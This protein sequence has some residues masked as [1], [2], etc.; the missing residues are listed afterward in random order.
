LDLADTQAREE[1]HFNHLT[2]FN[3]YMKFQGLLKFV[4]PGG[5]RK[6]IIYW[7][8]KASKNKCIDTSLLFDSDEES[9]QSDGSDSDSGTER[10]HTL[11]IEDEFIL[12]LM[13]LRLGLTN[14]DLLIRFR[15][16]AATVFNIFITW[17]NFLY[18]R[19]GAL[20][21]WLQ[22]GLYWTTCPKNS[23]RKIPITS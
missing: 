6:N 7:N 12:V 11:A 18:I 9:A 16:S 4:L 20:K 10:N 3:S 15:V 5:E 2:G 14:L 22:G 17:L 19:L 21:V 8:T 13:K 23:K 1:N